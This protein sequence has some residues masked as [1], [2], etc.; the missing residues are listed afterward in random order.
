MTWLEALILG[1]I[2]GLTEFLPISSSGHLELGKYLLG[3]SRLPEE[4]L[5]FTI[6]VHGATA[7]STIV[8]FRK[9]IAEILQGLFRFKNNEEL[10]FSLKIIVSMIPAAF[11]GVMFNDLIEQLFSGQMGGVRASNINHRTRCGR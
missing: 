7:L 2:Q 3:G 6:I 11:V 1:I 10:Q 9:D 8:I 4:S 5:L